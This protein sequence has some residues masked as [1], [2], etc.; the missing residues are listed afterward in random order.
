MSRMIAA[1]GAALMLTLP[2]CERAAPE[3]ETT[4]IEVPEGD[5]QARLMAMTDGERNAVFIRALRDAG[6]DCQGVE[7]STY[8]GEPDGVPTWTARCV[9]EQGDWLIL[10]G[11]DGI[12]QVVSATE[13]VRG[14]VAAPEANG[15]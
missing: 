10:L 13:A 8:Q 7:S 5:Y 12:V 2:G 4:D 6:R 1:A 14:G 15:Q 3:R 11:K 9:G